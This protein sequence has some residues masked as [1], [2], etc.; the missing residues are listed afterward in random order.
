[1]NT[2]WMPWYTNDLRIWWRIDH[3]F[4][5][6]VLTVVIRLLLLLFPDFRIL[7]FAASCLRVDWELINE[8]KFYTIYYRW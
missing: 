3:V 6:V 7:Y 5:D 4:L 2:K 8:P 1:M